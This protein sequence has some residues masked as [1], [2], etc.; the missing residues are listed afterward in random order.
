MHA[1]WFMYTQVLLSLNQLS[2][3]TSPCF[4]V[5]FPV[6]LSVQK[7]N[8]IIAPVDLV[9]TFSH[10]T[11]TTRA[12]VW[13][14]ESFLLNKRHCLIYFIC[15]D[16]LIAHISHTFQRFHSTKDWLFLALCQCSRLSLFYISS[17]TLPS[18]GG[19]SFLLPWPEAQCLACSRDCLELQNKS[20][21]WD[22]TNI[23][24][25]KSS[26][27]I[28]SSWKLQIGFYNCFQPTTHQFKQKNQCGLVQ[29]CLTSALQ[30]EILSL[31]SY[32]VSITSYIIITLC[33]SHLF[34]QL[35][36]SMLKLC[37]S[38]FWNIPKHL[39]IYSH[40]QAPACTL[41]SQPGLYRHKYM[42]DSAHYSNL[43]DKLLLVST[44]CW[45][46]NPRNQPES[47]CTSFLQLIEF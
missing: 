26:T 15:K 34:C 17:S 40:Y 3:S 16:L 12:A 38:M 39:Y 1:S 33:N 42:V 41:V 21:L 30:Y 45:I 7:N 5:I 24:T 46:M 36:S 25:C 9:Y 19:L 20:L 4:R 18:N 6:P 27:I 28:I 29:S 2:N 37:I 31:R 23:F 44:G 22:E 10:Q 11:S 14:L 13:G 8:N 32:S 47:S 35:F 43:L